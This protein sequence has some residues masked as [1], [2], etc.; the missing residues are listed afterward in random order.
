MRSFPRR[1]RRRRRCRR[2]RRCRRVGANFKE[3]ATF[4]IR[5]SFIFVGWRPKICDL[6]GWSRFQFWALY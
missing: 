5:R 1:R 3:T 6:S 4:E 2:C